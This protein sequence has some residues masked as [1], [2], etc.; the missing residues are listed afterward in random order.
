[1]TA[2]LNMHSIS[3]KRIRNVLAKAASS[4]SGTITP[5]QRGRKE[6]PNKSTDELLNLVEAFCGKL[7]TLQSHYS[8]QKNP[9]QLYL[10]PGS[11]WGGLYL[12]FQEFC[13]K[14]GHPK[15]A[16]KQSRFKAKVM[17]FK[18]S[19]QPPRSDTCATC[20]VLKLKL[21]SLDPQTDQEEI[22]A[23]T[24]QRHTHQAN[25]TVGRNFIN[26]YSKDKSAAIAA[27][28]IDLQQTLPTPRLTVSAQYYRCKLW[29]Y[30]LCIHNLKTKHPYF[31]VWNET[32]GKRIH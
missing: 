20:D 5:D 21:Q 30:N 1:M 23:L 11:T 7:P 27:I 9:E 10:P 15:D 14:E 19:I 31:Y 25:A 6:P 4:P 24:L 12:A 29:T 3:M 22:T 17:D 18:I 13:V 32:E 16:L 28:A 26:V 2:F 8:R